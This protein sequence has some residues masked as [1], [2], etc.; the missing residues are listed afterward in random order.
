M[1]DEYYEVSP[2][3][4]FNGN[5]KHWKEFLGDSDPTYGKDNLP[6]QTLSKVGIT[7]DAASSM[8]ESNLDGTGN[9]TFIKRVCDQA[10]SGR[11]GKDSVETIALKHKN[12]VIRRRKITR[13][14]N[15]IA[16]ENKKLSC[17]L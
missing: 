5:S 7:Y 6:E 11:L 10:E 2:G 3:C 15:N 14:F 16:R 13:E 1:N 12:N 8:S 4:T 9:T 17:L